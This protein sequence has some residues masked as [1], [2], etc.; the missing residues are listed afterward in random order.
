MTDPDVSDDSPRA[1]EA[2]LDLDVLEPRSL[3]AEWTGNGLLIEGFE[4]VEWVVD[5][6]A[7]FGFDRAGVR[8]DFSDDAL[9]LERFE[10]SELDGLARALETILD[11]EAL[12]L[13]LDGV[14]ADVTESYR[15]SLVETARSFGVELSLE[16]VSRHKAEGDA[17]NDWILVQRILDEHGVDIEYE[18]VKARYQSFYR[19]SDDDPGL[20]RRERVIPDESLMKEL[21]DRLQLGIVTGRTRESADR[22]FEHTWI[23][24]YVE[25]CVCL[26]DAPRKPNP[27]PVELL[28]SRLG[29]ERGWLVG[30]TPDD[31]LAARRAGALPL[32]IVSPS[33]T[34]EAME[35]ALREAG[36]AR[37][38]SELSDLLD[39][40]P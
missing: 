12:F 14:L 39:R 28:A 26:E 29:V 27:D 21:G 34:P 8:E 15:R 22:F 13:D 30:D 23:G 17:N 24:E 6:L 2:S 16:E 35:P 9:L 10:E 3:D 33:D 40:L 38:L 18:R 32:G 4:D 25:T 36:S 37:I 20:W 19:G 5:G 7:S 1:D 11:P 31:V